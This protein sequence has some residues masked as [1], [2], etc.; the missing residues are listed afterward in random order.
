MKLSKEELKGRVEDLRSLTAEQLKES[1]IGK[2]KEMRKAKESK[3]DFLSS[4][5]DLLKTLEVEL[6]VA[7]DVLKEK[8]L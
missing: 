8:E 1:I 5:N 4:H 7:L 3:S 2:V 6:E